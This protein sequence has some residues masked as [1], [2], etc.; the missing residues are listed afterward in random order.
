[1]PLSWREAFFRLHSNLSKEE[2]QK[3]IF[4]C[5]DAIFHRLLQLHEEENPDGEAF[6]IA[7]AL[8]TIR[9]FQVEKLGYREPQPDN[10]VAN[11]SSQT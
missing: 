9:R 7:G 1:M 8:R 5:E 4:D 10:L 3:R 6:E 11:Q 2:L